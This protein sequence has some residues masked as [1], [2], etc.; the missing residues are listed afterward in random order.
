MVAHPKTERWLIPKRNGGS[1]LPDRWLNQ[2][3][4]IQHSHY[5]GKTAQTKG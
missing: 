3:Q 2:P 4:I 1:L 5:P